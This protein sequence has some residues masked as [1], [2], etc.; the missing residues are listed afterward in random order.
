MHV[1]R[2]KGC[3]CLTSSDGEYF[4]CRRLI[5][6]TGLSVENKP[7]VPGIE[8]A[9]F[10]SGVSVDPQDFKNQRVLIIGKGNSAFELADTLIPTT[11]YIHVASPESL[12]LAWKS[13][14]VG[15]LRAV[16]NNFLDTY[17]LKCQNA[18]LDGIITKIHKKEEEYEVSISYSHAK[19][20]KEV[21][22]YDRIVLAAGFRFDNSIFDDPCR[23]AWRS[24][25]AS[26]GTNL[27]MGV[28]LGAQSLFR[29]HH[30]ADERF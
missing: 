25:I 27:R 6:A 4:T 10:Y 26:P 13:R 15:D 28:D 20:E 23:R 5:V 14:F 3:F 29:G 9:E 21:L 18:I 22:V 16:N 12:R 30:H 24:T 1:T 11:I 19:G 2:E 7:P 8:H 17:Q